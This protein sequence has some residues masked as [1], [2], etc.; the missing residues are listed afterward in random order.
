[1]NK[2]FTVILLFV[3]VY[4]SIAQTN[5]KQV[6]KKGEKKSVDVSVSEDQDAGFPL[7]GTWMLKAAQVLLPDGSL[8][9]DTAYGK[10]AKGILMI[11][12]D[13]QYSL[14][15]FRPDRPKFASGDKKR[16]TPKEYES[17]LLGISTHVGHIKMDTIH[18]VL[19][20][21]IDY[22]AYPNWEN[23]TQARQFRLSDDEL[24]YQVPSTAAA[25]TTAVSVWKR[26]K[27]SK[28]RK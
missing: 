24:Y 25:G 16:G 22:A 9:T 14:Q 19:T 21:H 18:K 26:V 15:I 10:N 20:F 17:A 5:S 13:G 27:K 1:M 2:L 11:D 4:S 8:V 12:S 28:A 23:T 7:A 3:S 6:A